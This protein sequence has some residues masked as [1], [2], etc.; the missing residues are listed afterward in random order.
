[1]TVC[2]CVCVCVVPGTHTGVA[3]LLHVVVSRIWVE[4][5]TIVMIPTPYK[6]K[7]KMFR[8]LHNYPFGVICQNLTLSLK[9]E[10]RRPVS[11]LEAKWMS[12]TIHEMTVLQYITFQCPSQCF[13][14]LWGAISI[15]IFFL[16][17]FVLQSSFLLEITF[18]NDHPF[19]DL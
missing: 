8:F 12:S 10:I 2:V 17:L 13:I 9:V 3:A 19:P 18:N 7:K 14:H 11:T 15:C 4:F 1:M 16:N 5:L 6:I